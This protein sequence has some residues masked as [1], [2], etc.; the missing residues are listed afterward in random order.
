MHDDLDHIRDA[1]C[2]IPADD[3]DIW[4]RM[5]MAIK[6]EVGDAGFELW[7]RLEPA[8]DSYNAHDA[9][10]TWK[11]INANGKVTAGTLFHEAKANGWRDDGMH[12]KPTPEELAERRRIAAERAAKEEAE[13]ARERADTAERRRRSGRRDRGEGRSS[14]SVRKRFPRWRPCERLTRARRRRSWAMRRSR[15]ATC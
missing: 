8:S 2:F 15:A 1:L 5:G 14:L 12:Q 9:R 3:R 4:L 11:S 10:A 6:S 13:I 7:E